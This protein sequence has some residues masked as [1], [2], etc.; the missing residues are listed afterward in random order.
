[1]PLRQLHEN[2]NYEEQILGGEASRMP[3][4]NAHRHE[5]ED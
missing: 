3:L 2:S 1:M 4:S 5:I